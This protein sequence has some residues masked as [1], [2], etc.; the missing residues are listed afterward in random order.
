MNGD[1][2]GM[3]ELFRARRGYNGVASIGRHSAEKLYI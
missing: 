2:T 1:G 3:D